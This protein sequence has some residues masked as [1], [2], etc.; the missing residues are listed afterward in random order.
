MLNFIHRRRL[1]KQIAAHRP[2]PVDA[3]PPW[4]RSI[5]DDNPDLAIRNLLDDPALGRIVNVDAD[6]AAT[7]E[8]ASVA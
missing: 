5:A 8:L 6:A 4:S 2:L 7:R 1:A 3:L